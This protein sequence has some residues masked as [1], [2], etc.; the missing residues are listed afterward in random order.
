MAEKQTSNLVVLTL[1]GQH[2]AESLFAKIEQMEKDKLVVIDDAVIIEREATPQQSAETSAAAS[3]MEKMRMPPGSRTKEMSLRVK[4]LRGKKGKYAAIGGGIGLLGAA[5]LGGP[6]GLAVVATAGIG[7]LTAAL[8]DF[9]VNDETVNSVKER[10]QPDTSALLLLGRAND[11][12]ALL[13]TLR[14]YD[15]KVVLT[16]LD[17]EVESELIARLQGS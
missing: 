5:I 13:A 9:G 15:A 8:K 2:A 17:P 7:A 10:L 3:N 12:D 14:Q 16:S 6:I 1:E 11:R 4:Q